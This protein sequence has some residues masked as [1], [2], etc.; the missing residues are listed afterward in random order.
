MKLTALLATLAI[1]LLATTAR[2]ESE[3]EKAGRMQWFNDARFG[4]F[5]HWGV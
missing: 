2:S 5:I 3:A 4:M 1:P